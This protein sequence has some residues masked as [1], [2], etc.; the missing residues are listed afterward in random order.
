MGPFG[1]VVYALCTATSGL[2]AYLLLRAYSRSR[3]ALL[4]C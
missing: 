2:C 1:G 3:S 4:I